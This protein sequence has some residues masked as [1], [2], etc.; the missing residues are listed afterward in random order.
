MAADDLLS[1]FA[2]QEDLDDDASPDRKKRRVDLPKSAARSS[3]PKG[4][5][6]APPSAARSSSPKGAALAP[7]A[8]RSSSPKGA[9]LAPNAKINSPAGKAAAASSSKAGPPPAFPVSKKRTPL[10]RERWTSVCDSHFFH[11]QP[12]DC[13]PDVP[14]QLLFVGINPSEQAWESGV[15]YG[16]PSNLFWRILLESGVVSSGADVSDHQMKTAIDANFHKALASLQNRLG[17]EQR[18]GWTDLGHTS[19]GSDA[20]E[21]SEELIA[22]VW[23]PN[24]VKRA[25]DHVKRVGRGWSPTRGCC[26]NRVVHPDENDV[27]VVVVVFFS[28]GR[29]C[30]CGIL[31]FLY[32]FLLK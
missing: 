5:A 20:A 2:F 11:A 24:F 9:A 15:S 7:S 12:C 14:L 4:A 29:D 30:S 18:F 25:R 1:K 10:F 26:M 23:Y 31:S 21:F 6:L 17:F 28:E 32:F 13:F 16:N 3:S 19:P 8:A 27:L 22:D